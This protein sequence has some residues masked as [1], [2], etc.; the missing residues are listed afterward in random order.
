MRAPN[1]KGGFQYFKPVSNEELIATPI[2]GA[3]GYVDIGGK[4]VKIA[5]ADA[6]LA[7]GATNQPA[8]GPSP[9]AGPN[10]RVTHPDGRTGQVP[11]DEL[12]WFKSQGWKVAQ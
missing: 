12:S 6:L 9:T 2:P 3:P 1:G 10:I 8:G 11:K 5:I 7:K 4:H